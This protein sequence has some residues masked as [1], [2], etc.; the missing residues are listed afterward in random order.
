M[1]IQARIAGDPVGQARFLSAL[2][3]RSMAGWWSPALSGTRSE[4]NGDF[5][6]SDYVVQKGYAYASQNKGVLNLH[7]DRRRSARLPSQSGSSTVRSLL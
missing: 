2:A 7:F 6:W 5:A 1:Q 4:Y 3:G